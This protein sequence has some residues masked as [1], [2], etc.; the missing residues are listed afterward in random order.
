[1]PQATFLPTNEMHDVP[2]TTNRN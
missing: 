2:T 1:M